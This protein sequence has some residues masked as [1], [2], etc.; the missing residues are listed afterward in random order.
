LS[1]EPHK[2]VDLILK[3]LMETLQPSIS[4]RR[5]FEKQG[6]D[7]SEELIQEIDQILNSKSLVVEKDRDSAGYSCYAIT[8]TGQD[9]LKTY[10]SYTKYLK[11]L[12]SEK[13]RVER[14]KKKKPYNAQK[15][16]KGEA[17]TPYAPPEKT[18]FQRNGI[19]LVILMLFAALFY[20]V[21]KLT[22]T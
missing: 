14:A 1:V 15:D 4:V 18:F 22:E 5:V 6:I 17:P 11:G 3:E 8:E 13:K 12:E 16:F 10:G 21:S 9:F 7:Y 2:L 19:G 20:I